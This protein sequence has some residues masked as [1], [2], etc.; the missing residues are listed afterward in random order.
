MR[1][2]DTDRWYNTDLLIDSL[3]SVLESIDNFE[4]TQLRISKCI[5]FYLLICNELFSTCVIKRVLIP[6]LLEASQQW[7]PILSLLEREGIACN[8][9]K[10]GDKKVTIVLSI[11]FIGE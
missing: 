1:R 8:G 10:L 7:R 4:A 11:G 2:R 3:A 6:G 5:L 9:N